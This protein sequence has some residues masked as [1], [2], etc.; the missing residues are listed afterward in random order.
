MALCYPPTAL[1]HVTGCERQSYE[2]R[3]QGLA[4]HDTK[5]SCVL[6]PY[7]VADVHDMEYHNRANH[8]WYPSASQ[9]P[10]DCGTVDDPQYT[11]VNCRI[12]DASV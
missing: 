11:T 5:D 8:A 3:S 10:K 4:L 6:M 2:R 12:P 7:E 1:K 9:D